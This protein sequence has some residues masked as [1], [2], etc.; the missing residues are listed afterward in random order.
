MCAI[1][2]FRALDNGGKAPQT[3]GPVS[4]ECYMQGVVPRCSLPGSVP[5]NR[6][7]L[8]WRLYQQPLNVVG[9]VTGW[10]SENLGFSRAVDI[11][12]TSITQ[13]AN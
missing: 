9:V 1:S 11:I 2:S 3:E 7:A 6:Y 5:P 12:P 13:Y 10:Y 8:G 4:N